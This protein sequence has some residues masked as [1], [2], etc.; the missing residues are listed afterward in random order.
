[1]NDGAKLLLADLA[2]LCVSFVM[3]LAF[4]WIAGVMIA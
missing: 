1:M 3:L 4:V 2:W